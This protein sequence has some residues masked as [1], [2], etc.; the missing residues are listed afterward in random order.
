MLSTVGNICV[1]LPGTVSAGLLLLSACV[2]IGIMTGGS[3]V[4]YYLS[5]YLC[6]TPIPDL[7][8]VIIIFKIFYRCQFRKL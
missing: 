4:F 1:L 7:N 2:Y 6:S 8:T 3:T 5:V